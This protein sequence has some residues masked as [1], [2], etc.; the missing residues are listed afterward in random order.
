LTHTPR[1]QL[2]DLES[3]VQQQEIKLQDAKRALAKAEASSANH[4][5]G[6]V[7]KAETAEGALASLKLEHANSNQRLQ[8]EHAEALRR[9]EERG[10]NELQELAAKAE[11]ALASQENTH[12][13]E[14]GAVLAKLQANGNSEESGNGGVSD[15][16][17]PG[18]DG[19]GEAVEALK[20]ENQRLRTEHTRELQRHGDAYDSSRLALEE[21]HALELTR[22]LADQKTELDKAWQQIRD[23]DAEKNR[24]VVMERLALPV[25]DPYSDLLEYYQRWYPLPSLSTVPSPSPSAYCK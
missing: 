5:K 15:G 23:A 4:V 14:K 24:K 21:A 8:A 19:G 12:L 1:P 22:R 9:V 25:P 7:D 18:I 2:S 10:A 3:T 16:E 11:A 13:H 17:G 6:L 20:Q